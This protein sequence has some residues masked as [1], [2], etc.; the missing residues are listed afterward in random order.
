MR[1][2]SHENKPFQKQVSSDFKE[3]FRSDP[4]YPNA[5][6]PLADRESC[7]YK[8]NSRFVNKSTLAIVKALE[9][10]SVDVV[11]RELW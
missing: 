11:P 5:A 9:N 2:L 3:L 7:T 4:V 1:V 6:C 8:L 10:S